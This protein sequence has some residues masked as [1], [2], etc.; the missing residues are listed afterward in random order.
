M[1]VAQLM[2]LGLSAATIYRR[3]RPG[4]PWQRPLPGVVLLTTGLP[5]RRQQISAALAYGGPDAIIT[6]A[7]ACRLIG[8]SEAPGPG[9]LVHLLVPHGRRLHNHG[10][11]LV[12]RTRRMPKVWTRNG[13]PVAQPTR[14]VLD[15][16]RRLTELRPARA[17]LAEAVQRSF[18]TLDL[19]GR[20]LDAGGQRGS[21]LPRR[22]LGELLPGTRSVAE[23]DAERLW[24]KSGL[25]APL[26]NRRLVG[27]SGEYLGRPDAWFDDVGLAWEIDSLAHHFSVA[28]FER[29]I[30]RNQRY[31]TAGILCLQTLPSEL[32]NNPERVIAKL[33]EAY[34]AAAAHPRPD[35]RVK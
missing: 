27:P 24:V 12:E 5:S 10:Q 7:E 20:E 4:G 35:V 18:T 25:P 16:A 21:A 17:L 30:A 26:W 14:A 22:V 34:A 8:L 33:R 3:C 1:R 2:E 29:T 32:I 6:G 15:A 13:F 9:D 28:A 23:I 31:V 11:V 19:L